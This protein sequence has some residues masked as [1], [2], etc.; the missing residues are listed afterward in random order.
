LLRLFSGDE[1][2]YFSQLTKYFI[3]FF[4]KYIT[5][6]PNRTVSLSKFGIFQAFAFVD[7]ILPGSGTLDLFAVPFSLYKFKVFIKEMETFKSN[8]LAS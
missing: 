7:Q 2:F 4:W 8:S 5:V 6:N 3:L 1:F